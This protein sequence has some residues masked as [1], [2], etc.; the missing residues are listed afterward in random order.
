MQRPVVDLPQPDLAHQPQGLALADLEAD[1]VDGMNLVDDAREDAAL[2]REALAQVADLEERL[3]GAPGAMG[4]VRST[5][6][7][8]WPGAT[9]L[10]GGMAWVQMSIGVLAA[11]ARSGSR[12]AGSSRLGTVPWIDSS[13][14]WR[15][16]GA[17]D[18]RDGADQALG[19]GM[20]RIAEQ[21]LD[22][23][24]LDDLAGIHHRH[25][26][27]GLGDH[28]HGMGDQHDRHAELVLH[29]L[30]QLQDLRLD[31]D[32]ERRRRLVGDQELG[33]AGKRHG[34]HDALAHA[35][36]ELVRIVVHA[37]AAGWGC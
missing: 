26:L 7:T 23:R 16:D 25:P 32:V 24:L 35:A 13:R 14:A 21:R 29:L 20:P 15:L 10:S 17:V 22:R 3:R 28:A 5:H 1:A 6:A 34:D 36:G 27:A 8:R 19:V 30:H 2:D 4:R 9:S 18:A 31:G 33:L 11:R 12:A 37:A